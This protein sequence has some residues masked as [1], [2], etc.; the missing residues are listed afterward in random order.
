[1]VR[2]GKKKCTLLYDFKTHSNAHAAVCH[3]L[4]KWI[5]AGPGSMCTHDVQSAAKENCSL[6]LSRYTVY[7]LYM[8]IL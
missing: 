3:H 7:G 5:V 1:M 4:V 6:F 8:Y 2:E